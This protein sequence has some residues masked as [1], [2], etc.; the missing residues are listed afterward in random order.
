MRGFSKF[1]C[2][3]LLLGFALHAAT[4]ER[5]S[6][7]DMIQKSTSIAR[8]RVLGSYTAVRGRIIYT[9]YQIQ[10]SELWKGAPATELDVV[11]PGGI[12]GGLRQTFPGV[13]ALARGS[14]YVLFLWTARSSGL[15]HVIGLSQGIFDLRKDA[16]GDLIAVQQATSGLMLDSAGRTVKND[17]TRMRLADL[18]AR[19][20]GRLAQGGR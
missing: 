1:G 18:R 14:E 17:A 13:P 8:A 12:S 11:L 7:D 2:S 9:H 15:T 20:T 3:A 6:L 4:L 10:I 5:L 16:S 19:V